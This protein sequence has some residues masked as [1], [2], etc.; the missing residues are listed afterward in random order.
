VTVGCVIVVESVVVVTVDVELTVV[1]VVAKVV[2]VDVVITLLVMEVSVV[3]SLVVV[4][5]ESN[6]IVI[7]VDS[8][9]VPDD[10]V[11]TGRVVTVMDVIVVVEQEHKHSPSGTVAQSA[12]E[13]HACSH[14][15]VSVMMV[16]VINS[17]VTVLQAHG[18]IST[19]SGIEQSRTEQYSGPHEV[20]VPVVAVGM[21][22]VTMLVFVV[23][24]EVAQWQGHSICTSG[25]AHSK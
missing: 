6:V 24:V 4:P 9:V 3:E 12:F 2:L 5:V 8:T 21:V 18:H 22:F 13:H 15:F 25:S 19:T 11:V 7:V 14:V 17:V 20:L 23:A 1:V 16:V 10:N